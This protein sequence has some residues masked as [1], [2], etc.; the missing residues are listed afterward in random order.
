[1]TILEQGD[2][3]DD[4]NVG[5]SQAITIYKLA[6]MVRDLVNP[7]IKIT[8]KQASNVS[9]G[10][11]VNYFYVPDTSKIRDKLDVKELATLTESID[12]YASFL[13][14]QWLDEQPSTFGF[15]AQPDQVLHGALPDSHNSSSVCLSRKVSIGRQK[16]LCL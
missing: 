10:N 6:H 4:F 12:N 11:P 8:V 2:A 15:A 14:E 9:P 7:D 5:S 1:M 16:P 3:G 13:S